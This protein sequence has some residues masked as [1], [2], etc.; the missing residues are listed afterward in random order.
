MNSTSNSAGRKGR[1]YQV[2]SNPRTGVLDHEYSRWYWDQLD[3]QIAYRQAR[4][5][6]DGQAEEEFE[7]P[8][9]QT[10]WGL[11]GEYDPPPFSENQTILLE[12]IHWISGAAGEGKTI[13]AYWNLL[14]LAKDL[15]DVAIYEC[16]M[17][18]E[19]AKGLLRNLGAT[20]EDLSHIHYYRSPDGEIWDLVKR[21]RDFCRHLAS[22]DIN[23]LLYD[24][25]A[26]LIA[27]AGGDENI[28]RDVRTFVTESCR[29]MAEDNGL[30]L[31]LDHTGHVDT[32]RARGSTDKAAGCDVN[33]ILK[34]TS[35]FKRGKSGSLSLKCT[36]DRFGVIEKNATMDIQVVA[37]DDGSLRLVASEWQ[38]TDVIGPEDK[39][40][41]VKSRDVIWEALTEAMTPREIARAT[42]KTEGAVKMAL[43]RGEGTRFTNIDGGKWERI[44]GE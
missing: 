18:P 20:D 4:E 15:F 23:V 7:Q 6:L 16:E 31:V 32:N 28:A 13:F 33:L 25:A 44:D 38:G 8:F 12:G 22:Q 11:V 43:K 27:A 3:R 26:P 40:I 1:S 37:K 9:T 17:G 42:D 29:P 35:S 39:P 24:A 34:T 30:V 10:A 5:L 2:I 21:G 14:E 41:R 36:K 19:R